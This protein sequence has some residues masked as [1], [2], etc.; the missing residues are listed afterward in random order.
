MTGKIPM[1]FLSS[2]RAKSFAVFLIPLS[3]LALHS[4]AWAALSTPQQTLNRA[5]REKDFEPEY[6]PTVGNK[7]VE[8]ISCPYTEKD[9][10][11]ALRHLRHVERVN[12]RHQ[13]AVTF[14]GDIN[15]S[16]MGPLDPA[17]AGVHYAPYIPIP[18]EKFSEYLVSESISPELKRV[19]FFKTRDG[20]E[21]ARYFIHPSKT[22]SYQ[23]LIDR[24]GIVRTEFIGFFSASPRSMYIW[25]PEDPSIAPFVAK[26]SLHYIIDGSLRINIPQKA[27]RSHFV[28]ESFASISEADKKLYQFDFMPESV[29]LLPEKKAT[30]TI[31]REVPQTLLIKGKTYVPGFYFSSNDSTNAFGTK[32]DQPLL[33]KLIANSPD[34]LKASA[35]VLR[36]LLRLVAYLAFKQGFK[37]ELHEQNLFFEVDKEGNP[38]GQIIVKDLDGFRVDT[39]LRIRQGLSVA[40]LRKIFKP[41]VYSKFSKASGWGEQEMMGFDQEAYDVFVKHTFGYSFCAVLKCSEKEKQ[42]LYDQLDLIMAQEAAKVTG[43]N[44]N[45]NT[46]RAESESAQNGL[47]RIAQRYRDNL[48]ES[49]NFSQRDR[50]TLR[51]EVQSVLRDEFTRLRSK[52]RASALL[53]DLNSPQV[54]L[55]RH[56]DVIE[57]REIDPET[58]AERAIGYASFYPENHKQ[59]I[60]FEARYKKAYAS[61]PKNS[62]A[63]RLDELSTLS[64]NTMSNCAR[65]FSGESFGFALK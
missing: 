21:W 14:D 47:Q 7:G 37:G 58:F 64:K 48:N 12:A 31:Y 19:L 59:T 5:Q 18:A 28:N 30:A 34:R 4:S 60:A 40:G 55:V 32:T 10:P 29:Q 6:I 33:L 11:R 56:A 9:I 8:L 22:A 57:A 15:I 16:V 53:G 50:R 2:L 44:V 41:F 39:E 20:K 46:L 3:I 24:Y 25:H 49:V 27:A 62:F 61:T 63:I 54:Y 65:L 36:P 38:T 45:P 23:D 13:D 26:T 1:H 42:M 43:F 51:G 17:V 52:K 35:E